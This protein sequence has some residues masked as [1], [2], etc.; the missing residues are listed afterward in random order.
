MEPP[1]L[2][3]MLSRRQDNRNRLLERPERAQGADSRE[4]PQKH[5]QT[6]DWFWGVADAAV[7]EFDLKTHVK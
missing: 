3:Q 5:G 6:G 1:R 7:L 4:S 2:L